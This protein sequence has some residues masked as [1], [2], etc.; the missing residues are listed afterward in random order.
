MEF[1][2]LVCFRFYGDQI[3]TSK[4]MLLFDWSVG[5]VELFLLSTISRDCERGS[6]GDLHLNNYAIDKEKLHRIPVLTQLLRLRAFFLFLAV[7]SPV[8]TRRYVTQIYCCLIL[9]TA[10]VQSTHKPLHFVT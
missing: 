2:Y 6:R 3:Q 1:D 7:V 4:L 8:A 5:C 10:L 9:I